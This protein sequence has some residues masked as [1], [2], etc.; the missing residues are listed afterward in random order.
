MRNLLIFSLIAI[1]SSFELL[2]SESVE[3]AEKIENEAIKDQAPVDDQVQLAGFYGGVDLGA[4]FLKNKS[5]SN[6]SNIDRKKTKMGF[7]MDMF[8]GYNCQFGDFVFGVEGFMDYR[9]TS[10]KT[11]VDNKTFSLKK[12]YSFGL[13]PK[14]GYNI[15]NNI[16]GY[17]N[18][19]TL[20]SKYKVR[21][22]DSKSNPMKTS[23]F[24]GLGVEQSFGSMF[25][26][27][28]LNKVFKKT[29]SKI[30][31]V[32]VSADSYT[33]KIGGGYRF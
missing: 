9:T 24:V 32:N 27:G 30:N 4:D 18:F 5:H 16:T 22:S 6:T 31:N 3:N 1:C 7:L 25:V 11:T 29:I 8:T 23:L 2:A 14:I 12:K 26:R 20:T 13:A 15:Y 33:F 28:E 10:P 19:G 21:S 17:V